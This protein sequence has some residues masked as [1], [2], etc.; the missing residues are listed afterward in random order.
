MRKSLQQ[1]IA[2]DLAMAHIGARVGALFGKPEDELAN[3]ALGAALGVAA[4]ELTAHLYRLA[5]ERKKIAHI[6][7]T[8]KLP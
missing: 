1:R 8:R 3:A 5:R 4:A 2:V 7:L 6:S